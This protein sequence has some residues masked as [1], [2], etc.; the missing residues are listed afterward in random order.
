VTTDDP[1][2]NPIQDIDGIRADK[3]IQETVRRQLVQAR[4]GQGLFR[5]N[6]LRIEKACRVT[7]VSDSDF[8]IASHVKPWRVANNAE[9]LDGSNGLM[10]APHIDRLFDKGFITL[11]N[12][13]SLLI[14][15]KLPK[16]VIEAWALTVSVITKPLSPSQQE[17]MA[18][19]RMNVFLG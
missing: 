14:S 4:I 6:V 11:A 18:Y 8:L 3:S 16:S 7:G 15:E 5:S 9:R 19:H 10:L 13:G 2:D 17:F 1:A 12:D